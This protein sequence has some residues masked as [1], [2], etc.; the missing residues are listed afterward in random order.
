[1]IIL[2]YT[3][4]QPEKFATALFARY[5]KIAYGNYKLAPENR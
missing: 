5:G 2:F 3:Y 4:G 1:M